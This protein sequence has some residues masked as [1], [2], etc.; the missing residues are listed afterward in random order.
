LIQ[1]GKPGSNRTLLKTTDVGRAQKVANVVKQSMEARVAAC[2]KVKS[3]RR[4]KEKKGG[5]NQ[6]DFASGVGEGRGQIN[7]IL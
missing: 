1:K 5:N 3:S 7:S 2:T 4:A 6:M